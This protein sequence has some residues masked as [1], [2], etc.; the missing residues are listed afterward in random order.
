MFECV[1]RFVDSWTCE[2]VIVRIVFM[3]MYPLKSRPIFKQRIWGG[4]KLREFFDKEISPS[5]RIGESW[6]L[7]DLPDDKSEIVNGELAGMTLRSA[8]EKYSEEITGR[9]ESPLPFPLL[10]KFLDAEELEASSVPRIHI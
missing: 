7:A 10:I 2:E 5:E 4:Q 9:K 8:V 3:E 6:E 1:R